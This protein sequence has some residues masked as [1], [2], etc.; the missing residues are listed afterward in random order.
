MLTTKSTSF[1]SFSVWK[2]DRRY[3]FVCWHTLIP[4][5]LRIKEFPV[6][7]LPNLALASAA[8][9]SSHPAATSLPKHN[10]VKR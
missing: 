3:F 7:M 8:V 4:V 6:Q 9:S 2:Q 1:L 5:D 10:N